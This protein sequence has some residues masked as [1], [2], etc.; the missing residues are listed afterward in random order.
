M[1]SGYTFFNKST[2]WKRYV[3]KVVSLF[4]YLKQTELVRSRLRTISSLLT[5][6]LIAVAYPVTFVLRSGKLR[7]PKELPEQYL[8]YWDFHLGIWGTACMYVIT[9][10][11]CILYSAWVQTDSGH[12]A[13]SVIDNVNCISKISETYS[14][15]ISPL[16][17]QI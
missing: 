16:P 5:S 12:C 6:L 17:R 3:F 2:S 13:E 10:W 7:L 4:D 11:R 1:T 8:K 14:K 9:Y 15:N